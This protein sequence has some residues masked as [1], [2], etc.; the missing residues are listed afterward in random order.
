MQSMEMIP[1]ILATKG[2]GSIGIS[3]SLILLCCLLILRV[4]KEAITIFKPKEAQQSSML[5]C[6]KHDTFSDSIQ[7]ATSLLDKLNLRMDMLQTDV[8]EMKSHM[9][10]DWN[11]AWQR[12]RDTEKD[13]IT[14]QAK[15]N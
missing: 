3:A 14:L 15:V 1:T 4:A 7:R 13:V 10:R 12:I 2:L 9:E 8:S 5:P 11:E 6:A